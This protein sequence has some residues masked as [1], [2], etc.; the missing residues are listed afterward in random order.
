MKT[1]SSI[2][3]QAASGLSVTPVQSGLL[4]RKCACGGTP[5][6][7]GECAECRGKRLQRKPRNSELATQNEASAPPIVHDVLLLPSQPFD[8]VT[9]ALMEPRFGHDF[10]KIPA[11]VEN[12]VASCEA[13][14]NLRDENPAKK[15]Y[16]QLIV[17]DSGDPMEVEADRMADQVV[18]S[19]RVGAIVSHSTALTVQ[20][21]AETDSLNDSKDEDFAEQDL[22]SDEELVATE[23]PQLIGDESGR[24]KL[25]PEAPT[26]I[27]EYQI[28]IPDTPGTPLGS[29]ARTFMEN[30][31][32]HDFSRVR[33]HTDR[34]A[35]RSAQDL[36][37]HAYTV[38]RHIYFNENRYDPDSAEGKRLLAHELTHV[39]QQARSSDLTIQRAPDPTRRRPKGRR[40][41]PTLKAPHRKRADKPKCASE[42]CDGTCAAPVEKSIRHPWCSNEICSNGGAASSSNFIRHLDVDLATQMVTA[43][44]GTA[45]KTLATDTFLSS[46]RP[47][48]TPQG[49]HKIG[50]KCGPCHTNMHAHGMAWFTSFHN[51]LQFGFHDSQKVGKGV[52]SLGC[53]R[54]APCDKAKWIHDNTASGTTTVCIHTGDHCKPK[55]PKAKKKGKAKPSPKHSS[56]E[57]PRTSASGD[58]Q[59]VSDAEPAAMDMEE[60]ETEGTPT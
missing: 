50:R 53:V 46:P 18:S 49:M 34:V 57:A 24:P 35:A 10:S 42:Q 23:D 43:E 28:A 40:D 41:P 59:L 58:P 11:H 45:T 5:G 51:D 12:P 8:A 17:S 44:L 55:A 54:V 29:R 38:G 14:T 32:G 2:Q 15:R 9:R 16:F 13:G 47:G 6:R 39:V 7:T 20:R 60:E 21:Q 3:P 4:Q 33:V 31:F 56:V 27:Q 1:R 22:D 19:R 48:V 30:R 25:A 36:Q 26:Q 37:A 52:H